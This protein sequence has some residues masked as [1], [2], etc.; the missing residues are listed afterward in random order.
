MLSYAHIFCFPY[1]LT[2]IG[3]KSEFR[4]YACHGKQECQKGGDR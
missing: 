3:E 1:N 2:T 4:E